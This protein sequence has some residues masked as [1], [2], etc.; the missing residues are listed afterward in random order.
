M[1]AIAKS[2]GLPASFVEFRHQATHEELPSLGR[3]RTESK[4]ALAWLWGYY[5]ENLCDDTEGEMSEEAR[6]EEEEWEKGQGV[7]KWF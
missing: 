3:L 5:W 1:Y 6:R 2:I 4:N 7:T